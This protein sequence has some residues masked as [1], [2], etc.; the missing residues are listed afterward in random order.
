[1]AVQGDGK[2]IFSGDVVLPG[3]IETR[4]ERLSLDGWLDT[5][6]R[7]VTSPFTIIL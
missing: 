3:P 4:V 1:M 2:M 7:S 5:S 6:Y